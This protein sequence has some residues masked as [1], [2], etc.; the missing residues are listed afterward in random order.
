[1]ALSTR[2]SPPSGGNRAACGK[3]ARELHALALLSSVVR[4]PRRL[5]LKLGRAHGQNDHGRERIAFLI[6]KRVRDRLQLRVAVRG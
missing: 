1:V 3:P 6:E 2:A 5:V 4:Q